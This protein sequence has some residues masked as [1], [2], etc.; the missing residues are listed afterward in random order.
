MRSFTFMSRYRIGW[1]LLFAFATVAGYWLARSAAPGTRVSPTLPNPHPATAMADERMPEFRRAERAPA[2]ARARDNEAR[3]AGAVPNERVI[4]FASRESLDAFLAGLGDGIRVLGR[5]DALNALRIGFDDLASLDGLLSGDE[6]VSMIFPV[7][8]PMPGN[9]GAQAGAVPLGNGLLAWLGIDGMDPAG[10]GVRIAILD[11]GI[12]A[13]SAFGGNL[14]TIDL[15]ERL[16]GAELN[17]HGTAVASMILGQNSLIPGVAPNATIIDVRVANDFGT[18]N[19]WLLAQGILAAVDAGAQ[20]INISLGSDN[21][22]ALVRNALDYAQSAGVVVVAPAGNQGLDRVA[23]PAA[24]TS[25]VA[26]GATDA[27]GNHVAFSN[28]GNIDLAAPGFGLN[29]AYPGDKAVNVDGT[30]FSAPIVSGSLAWIM[31]TRNVSA[32]QALAIMQQNLNDAG[33]AGPDPSSGGGLPALDRVAN[34]HTPGIFDAAVA[35]HHI[36]P[37]RQDRPYAQLEVVVQNR[38]T[39]PLLNTAVTIQHPGGTTTANITSLLPGAVHPVFIPIPNHSYQDG[40]TLTFDSNVAI[41][42]GIDDANPTNNRRVDVH[43]PTAAP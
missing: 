30:S 28:S 4:V 17:G 10:D 40:A 11:T 38:G 9:V 19:S 23:F 36:T 7:E 2:P 22:S 3:E 31:S 37:P 5:I 39:E 35:S 1:I 20:I 41:R 14:T 27:T 26:V 21:D 13:H 15:V 34:M 24:N 33:P 6:E 18:S 32:T 43:V 16:G 42:Q 12:F 25:V 29:A 8:I